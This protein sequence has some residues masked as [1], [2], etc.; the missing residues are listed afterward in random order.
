MFTEG[1]TM[2][3]QRRTV[4]EVRYVDNATGT[5]CREL[6]WTRQLARSR[7]DALQ[8]AGVRSR[9]RP[10]RPDFNTCGFVMSGRAVERRRHA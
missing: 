6:W 7:A 4:F 9:V 1:Q 5:A 2:T 3:G 8:A 10:S